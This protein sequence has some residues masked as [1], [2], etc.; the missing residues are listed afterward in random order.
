M[1]LIEEKGKILK[2]IIKILFVVS[3]F[4]PLFFSKYLFFP[5]VT[6]KVLAFRLIVIAVYVLFVAYFILIKKVN[7]KK[8]LIWK[9]FLALTIITLIAGLFGVNSY[10]S[11]WSNIERAEG[12]FF[13]IHL[14]IYFS[15]LLYFFKTK[16]D[17][18]WLFR[19]SLIVSFIVVVYGL[20]QSF[21]IL[22]A[23]T[24]S[25]ARLSSTLGNAAY[26]GS[27]MLINTFLAFYLMILDRNVF[28]RIFYGV[29]M[30]LGV[31]AVYMTQTRGALLGLIGGLAL[32]AL[33]TA[34][35]AKSK[36]IKLYS[37]VAIGIIVIFVAS[38]FIFKNST[39]IQGN[40]TLRRVASISTNDYTTQT[41]LLAWEVAYNGWTDNTKTILIGWGGENYNYA[42]SEYFPAEIFVDTGSRVWFDKAHS[43]IIEYF[44]ATG[45][46]GV[47]AYLGLLISAFWYLFKNKNLGV[48]EKNIF[49]GLLAGYTF[50]NLFVFDTVNTYILFVVILAFISN[51]YHLTDESKEINFKGKTAI[52]VILL[53]IILIPLSVKANYS[54]IVSNNNLLKAES[55]AKQG[56]VEEAYNAYLVVLEN[57]NN[58]TRFEA[59]QQFS[60]FVL[61]NYTS[62][63]D[64]QASKMFDDA[65]FAISKSIEE[66]PEG[67]K[68]YY[69]LNQLYLRSYKF[70]NARLNKILEQ[71]D[72]LISLG[73]TR[74]HTY[75]Q[76]GEAYFRKGDY[77]NAII[78][79]Q[80]AVA[81]NPKVIDTYINVF[82]SAVM[83]ENEELE[84]ETVE[85][86]LK[87]DSDYFDNEDVLLRFVPMF[88]TAG[89]MD[90][91]ISDLEKL[92]VI[93][94]EKPEYYSSLAMQYVGLGQKKKAEEV[95]S[96]LLG[97]DEQLDQQVEGFIENIYKAKVN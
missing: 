65:I 16:N 5:F 25:G 40:D 89:R 44:V 70:D 23:I 57:N 28:W 2:N 27:Y 46:I 39:V 8:S 52:G 92:I 81:V 78:E 76:I 91:V 86:I 24:S 49:I 30:V 15:L 32:V 20:M 58:L 88:K 79:Y 67:I 1:Q 77:E 54:A 59:R 56:H 82:V 69:N 14:F 75:F 95:I 48:L 53:L 93:N 87:L 63:P 42:F 51:T 10:N 4:I 13:W 36:K 19:V 66:D 6:T 38:I 62:Q 60:L 68:N 41:R 64:Y 74:A 22:G 17:F 21:G 26:L 61:A 18:K 34:F 37:A 94:P 90:R 43:V 9:W 55:Y 35:R 80:K 31:V 47:I 11:F 12:G 84:N 7:F 85:S 29:M 97:R 33:L 45:I 83:A 71:K 73:S 3:L 72:K 96:Q 50:A